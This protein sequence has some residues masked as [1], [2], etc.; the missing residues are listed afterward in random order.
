VLDLVG[1]VDIQELAGLGSKQ[2]ALQVTRLP[3]FPA[4]ALETRSGRLWTRAAVVDFIRRW[5][6]RPG[7]PRRQGDPETTITRDEKES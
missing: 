4:P 1:I 5:P 2:R 7:R 6:R 3:T